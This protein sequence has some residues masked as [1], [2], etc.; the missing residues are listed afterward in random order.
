MIHRVSDRARALE[1]LC[2]GETQLVEALKADTSV[3]RSNA[4]NG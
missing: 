3:I 2:R 1:D 4:S